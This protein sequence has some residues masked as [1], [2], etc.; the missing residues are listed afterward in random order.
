MKGVFYTQLTNKTNSG[1][2]LRWKNLGETTKM[3]S[4]A[5]FFLTGVIL[6]FSSIASSS[7]TCTD[8]LEYSPRQELP[9][10]LF[11]LIVFRAS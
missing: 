11:F 8:L 5:T 1:L 6:T 7:V 10:P 3:T 4:E 9:F 2:A